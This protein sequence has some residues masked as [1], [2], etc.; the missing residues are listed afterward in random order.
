MIMKYLALWRAWQQQ[1]YQN[2]LLQA[3]D[4]QKA[5][6]ILFRSIPTQSLHGVTTKDRQLLEIRLFLLRLRY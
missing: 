4:A 2:S 1:H 6:L 3:K 5:K